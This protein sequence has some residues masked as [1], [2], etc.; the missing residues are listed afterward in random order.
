MKLTPAASSFG[1]CLA[2]LTV[3]GCHPR[4]ALSGADGSV[5]TL[6]AGSQ[7]VATDV[8]GVA[9]SGAAGAGGDGGAGATGGAGGSIDGGAGSDGAAGLGA[10]GQG[11]AAGAG[12]AAATFVNYELTG[13]M[14]TLKA[15]RPIQAGGKLTYTKV[16][17]NE[18]SYSASCSIADYNHDGVADLSAGRRWYEG[19][20]FK[21][22][23]IFRGGHDA[24]PRAGASAELADGE[25]DDISDFPWDM[26]GDGWTDII[27]IASPD[28]EERVSLFPKPQTHATAYWYKNPADAAALAADPTE[29][30]GQSW[31]PTLMHGDVRAEQHGFVDVDG[32]GWPEIFGACRD[33]NPSQT[34]GY[35]RGDR[36]NPTAMWRFFPVTPKDFYPFPFGGVG[37]LH[38]LGF[39]DVNGDG[40]PD[41]LERGGPWLQQANGTFPG[42]AGTI[43]SCSGDPA[44]CGW[45]KTPFW[46]GNTGGNQGGAHMYAYDIDGDGDSD[47]FSADWAHGEG[48]AWYEQGADHLTFTKHYFMKSKADLPTYGVYFTEPHAAQAVDMDGDGVPDIITGKNRFTYPL[49]QGDPDP[50]GEPYLYVFK[51]VR[52][53]MPGESGKAHFEPHRV[54]GDESWVE[55]ATGLLGGVGVGQQIAIGMINDDG[56]PD[57]CVSSRLGL[58]VFLGK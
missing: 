47:V 44:S 50:H 31:K 1:F 32:D 29:V 30:T 41:L 46:N 28:T 26:D 56:I 12:G 45:I 21:K 6:D 39:G 8:N 48:L 51:T 2:A 16:V 14:P 36:S 42:G 38:G 18:L 53:A 20:S 27:N 49:D 7:E 22:E 19:P 57:I 4:G 58:Y 37:K 33:C 5:A 23:H 15:V 11:G 10:G 43:A 55:G 9:G 24:L 54:D 40:R 3:G 52:E 13:T 25:P 35:Y 34:K 17:V